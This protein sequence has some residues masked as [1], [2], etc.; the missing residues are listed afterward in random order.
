MA[1]MAAGAAAAT[2]ALGRREW[3]RARRRQPRR[4]D[5]A[6]RSKAAARRHG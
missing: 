3:S 1:D 4:Q 5:R 2:E 6:D